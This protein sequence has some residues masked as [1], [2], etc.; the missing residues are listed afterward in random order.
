MR[1][2]N[3]WHA[4]REARAAWELR[5]KFETLFEAAV[6][7]RERGDFETM[8]IALDAL[9]Y[10]PRYTGFPPL[11]KVM[12]RDERLACLASRYVTVSQFTN[13]L[14]KVADEIDTIRRDIGDEIRL[15]IAERDDVPE[16]MQLLLKG[17]VAAGI[18]QP[19]IHPPSRA[20]AQVVA[21]AIRAYNKDHRERRNGTVAEDYSDLPISE[22][23][24]L[25]R[26]C[27]GVELVEI[28]RDEAKWP[29]PFPLPPF[30]DIAAFTIDRVRP[31]YG[32]DRNT[33]VGAWSRLIEE[34][35]ERAGKSVPGMQPAAWALLL[36]HRMPWD[37]SDL[38][39]LDG[40]ELHSPWTQNRVVRIEVLS[41]APDDVPY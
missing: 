25:E 37:I 36:A 1:K 10:D 14:R 27:A 31:A 19:D 29:E 13:R 7:F 33:T 30:T 35:A 8:E 18:G 28:S 39:K 11:D 3:A 12:P 20:R 34:W 32:T 21:D 22:W 2:S 4:T 17:V 38:R 9:G 26:V 5:T 15:V 40:I 24:S 16:Y 6:A 23:R 41:E